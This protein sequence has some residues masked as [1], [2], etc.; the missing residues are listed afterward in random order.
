[1]PDDRDGYKK[2]LINK[3]R[4]T[5]TGPRIGV[6][7]PT[8]S[9]PD[10]EPGDIVAA[11]RH[12]EQLGFESVWAVDQ[13]V[14]GTGAPLVDSMI[15]LSAVAGATDRVK[16]GLGVVIVPLRPVAWIAKQVASMQKVSGDRVVLGVGVGGDRHDRSWAATGVPRRERGRRTDA[17][18]AVLP[19]LI[20]GKPTGLPDVAGAPVVE[21]APGANVPPMLVGGTSDAALR[22][23]VRHADGWIAVPV[24]PEVA[25]SS[26]DRIREFAFDAGRAVPNV[27]GSIVV[28]LDGDP[29]LPAL[30]EIV[31]R[32]ADPDGV[33]GMPTDAI[34]SMLV[35][36]G[37]DAVAARVDGWANL[38]A[39]RVVFT[40]AAG[41]WHR[42][43]E[44]LASAFH[45]SALGGLQR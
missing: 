43:V 14:A 16:L 39:E 2:E 27:T 36:G 32:L 6:F 44:L 4:T 11:A 23:A 31:K 3:R 22:R 40:I 42:Q 13:L 18:L 17:A 19:D 7:L 28:A 41:D 12:A 1:L 30:D 33:Y 25:A 34:P 8:M 45:D 20:A 26:V 24:R 35:T 37:A 15:A 10:S 5:M 29:A 38:G 9:A 21:L